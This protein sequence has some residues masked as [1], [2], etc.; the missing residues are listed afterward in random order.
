MEIPKKKQDIT[1]KKYLVFQG[2]GGK[3]NAYFGVLEALESKELHNTLPL[4]PEKE[5]KIKGVAGA[6]AGAITALNIALGMSVEDIQY[7]ADRTKNINDKDL[8]NGEG[9]EFEDYITKDIPH[10]GVY[11]AVEINPND[12]ESTKFD[13]RIG[14]VSDTIYKDSYAD[15]NAK[16]IANRIITKD[17]NYQTLAD[18][19]D[20][21]LTELQKE[22]ILDN[23]KLEKLAVYK[24]DVAGGAK[25]PISDKPTADL[26]LKKINQQAINNTIKTI[27]RNR[28]KKAHKKNPNNKIWKKLNSE[29]DDYFYNILFDRGMVCG[30]RI[31]EYFESLID[32]YLN[33]YHKEKYKEHKQQN[34][35]RKKGIVTFQEFYEI[36]NV[37]LR[38][39]GTNMLAGECVIFSKVST[40]YFPVSEAVGISM[41]IPGLFKPVYVRAKDKDGNELPFE[42]T[43]IKTGLYVDGGFLNNIPYSAFHDSGAKDEEILGFRIVEGPDPEIFHP[44]HPYFYDYPSKI[45]DTDGNEIE[46]PIDKLDRKNYSNYI[47]DYIKENKTIP[48]RKEPAEIGL[49]SPISRT[50]ISAT[51]IGSLLGYILE[52]ILTDATEDEISPERLDN[53]IYV[54]SYH[55][56]TMDFTPN[57]HLLDFVKKQSKKRTEKFLG[58]DIDK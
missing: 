38:M 27:A 55:I 29:F 36:T 54:Y 31:R 24:T 9:F 49:I 23:E 32:R 41:N 53:I 58:I 51:T 56:G 6:S 12:L 3:G 42:D 46:A 57:K 40:P 17:F 37:D 16:E 14:F 5:N 28:I 34:S 25:K 33:K 8:F 19:T 35:K 39:T 18:N 15:M 2:G 7:E 1:K 11:R 26:N 4:R 50:S 20:N 47:V 13:T 22:L 52:T 10:P 44:E 30:T 21:T 45:I 43:K 48:P